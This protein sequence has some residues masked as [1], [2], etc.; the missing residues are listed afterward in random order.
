M[1]IR[2]L[3]YYNAPRNDEP[4]IRIVT[5]TCFPF[6]DP[7]LPGRRELEDDEA[8]EN[9]REREIIEAQSARKLENS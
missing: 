3:L 9:K 7:I 2:I 4:A 5:S 8:G 6:N 1:L